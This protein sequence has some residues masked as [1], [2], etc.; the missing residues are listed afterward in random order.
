MNSIKKFLSLAE[1]LVKELIKQID[2]NVINFKKAEEKIVEFINRYGH[3]LFQEVT[4]NCQEPVME[5]RVNVNGEKAKY[6]S[7]RNLRFIDRFGQ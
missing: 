4:S 1:L 6:H 7:M 2:I 5:D 3:F